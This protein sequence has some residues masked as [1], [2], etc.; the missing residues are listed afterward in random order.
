MVG[1]AGIMTPGP[2]QVPQPQPKP[3]AR[4]KDEKA[5]TSSSC[6]SQRD[7]RLDRSTSKRKQPLMMP[8]FRKG[9]AGLGSQIAA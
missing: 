7:S 6:Q 3:L 9:N 2:N 4:S 8:T 1:A 5:P